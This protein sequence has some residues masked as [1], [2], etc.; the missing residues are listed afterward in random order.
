MQISQQWIRM[1]FA[2]LAVALLSIPWYL[3]NNADYIRP[4]STGKV[5]HIVDGDTLD[6][7]GI[8]RVR[9]VGV[10]T[11]EKDEAG[12]QEALD[13]LVTSCLGRDVEVDIDDESPED[14]YGRILG[15]VYIEGTNINAQ[16]LRLGHAEILYLPPSEF[17]PELWLS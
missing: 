8:G 15:V 3:A 11:P 1:T 12:Y 4:V 2:I 9:L 16:L 14:G 13:F 5:V 7:T 10:N 6:I 17:D